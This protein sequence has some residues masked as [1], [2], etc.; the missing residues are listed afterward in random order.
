M[1]SSSPSNKPFNTTNSVK[2]VEFLLD[3]DKDGNHNLVAIDPNTGYVTGRTFRPID[4]FDAVSWIDDNADKNLYFSVNEPRKGAP[5]GKLSK[6]DISHLRAIPV[7]IDPRKGQ[8]FMA[9]RA[10]LQDLAASAASSPTPPTYTVDSG[11]GFQFFWKLVNRIP[12]NAETST[13]AEEQ[14]RGLAHALGGGDSIQNIDRIMRLPFTTNYPDEKKRARGR[15]QAPTILIGGAGDTYTPN[16]LSTYAK[17]RK[18]ES[19]VV[20]LDP[21]VARFQAEIDMQ[22]VYEPVPTSVSMLVGKYAASNKRLSDIIEG[23]PLP[24]EDQ[25]GSAYRFALANELSQIGGFTVTQY[26]QLACSLP[27]CNTD[28][29]APGGWPRAF[30]RE[31]AK[32]QT[33]APEKFFSAT[34]TAEDNAASQAESLFDPTP[35]PRRFETISLDEA[36][37]SALT[38]S[39]KPLVKGLLDQ[40]AFSVVYGDSNVGKS[41]VVLDL[42]LHMTEGKPYAGMKTQ[43]AVVVYIAAEGGGG[44]RKRAKALTDTFSPAHPERFRIL[45]EAVNLRN[46][47][48]DL[49]GLVSLGNDLADAHNLPVVFVVDT[50]SRALA[51][52]DENSSVDFGAFI[53]NIDALRT[54]VPNAH[55]LVIHHT[56]KNKAAGSRGWSG[57][58][59]AIDTEIEVGPGTIEVVKQRDLDKSWKSGFKL[60]EQKL[61]FDADGD[62]V[63]SATVELIDF[64]TASAQGSAGEKV[65]GSTV[66]GKAADSVKACVEM[67]CSTQAHQGGVGLADVTS[68]CPVAKS[69]VRRALALLEIEGS[70]VKAGRGRWR[71]RSLGDDVTRL[72]SVYQEAVTSVL[73]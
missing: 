3:L 5:H 37:N 9:E 33:H 72:A 69:T 59:A 41:F 19:N 16:Q 20:D 71:P 6:S 51:G 55:V 28:K 47:Q 66:S 34:E 61:G 67:L 12:V 27:H 56:G 65:M 31:W 18:A 45:R 62:V 13:W 21:E 10:R 11:G 38:D 53:R 14:G 39:A 36:A 63:T 30:A 22:E 7:D 49:T 17:P 48:E 57:L 60:V 1:P 25:S 26:A 46:S 70:L 29:D 2:A 4:M 58:R 50:A 68:A 15:L 35:K 42:C 52:G 32:G 64:E 44:I 43:P 73:D 8:D 40:G 24:G 54:G 23:R